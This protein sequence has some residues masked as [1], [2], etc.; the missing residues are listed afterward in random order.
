MSFHLPVCSVYL[1]LIVVLYVV[2]ITLCFDAVDCVLEENV[3]V[4]KTFI[5]GTVCSE[6]ELE[7][8]AIEA[9]CGKGKH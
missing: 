2:T 5:V 4:P 6:F 1:S 3:H 8:P 7:R 9:L